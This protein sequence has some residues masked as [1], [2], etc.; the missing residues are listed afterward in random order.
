MKIILNVA[1]A[2][3]GLLFLALG[4]AF[5]VAPSRIAPQFGLAVSE[6][7]SYA[8]LRADFGALFFAIGIFSLMGLR[9]SARIWLAVPVAL[10]GIILLGRIAGLLIDGRSA[11]S[12]QSLVVELAAFAILAANWAAS[13]SGGFAVT[14]LVLVGAAA[15]AF[16]FQRR[17][18]MAVEK[19]MLERNFSQSVLASLPD[20]L[21]AGLCGSGAPLPDPNRAGPCV[22]VVAARHLYVV[23]TGE[24]SPRKLNLMGISPGAIEAIF[25]THFHSDHIGGLGEMMLQHWASAGNSQP[26][27]VYGPQGVETV[28]GGLNDAYKLDA[29][30]RVAHHGAATLPPSG[31]GGTPRPFSIPESGDWSGVV[32][33]RDG[34]TVTAF[35][36]NHKP[37]FPAVGY[38][39]DYKGRSVVLSGDTAPS[40]SL[41]RAAKGADILFHEGLQP[42]MVAL[43]HDAAARNGHGTLAKIMSDIPSYH[44]SPEEAAR[45]A[46][47]AGVRQLVFYHIIPPL[48]FAYLNAAFLGDAAKNYHGPITVAKDGMLFSLPAGSTVISLRGL[49]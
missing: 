7:A 29:K 45:I 33:T 28:V 26:V 8:T 36:V 32:F 10:L 2:L 21:H 37:V 31:A 19:A 14:A 13:G 3:A 49:L 12:V 24:G 41:E 40:Q 46:Q 39:F 48:P 22:F 34:V 5:F 9:K 35:S 30:Y 18:G 11:Q 4:L 15:C 47:E 23:D 38:R 20:G 43:M 1:T 27:D 17:V 25:L 42:A 44:T 6:S 16:V